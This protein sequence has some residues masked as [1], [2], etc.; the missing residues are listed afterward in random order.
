MKEKIGAVDTV[1]FR[2]VLPDGTL[3]MSPEGLILQTNNDPTRWQRFQMALGNFLDRIRL[4]SLCRRLGLYKCAG[5][6]MMN[7]GLTHIATAVHDY[8][9]F[10]SVGTSS[11]SPSDYTRNDCVTPVLTRVAAT[12]SYETTYVANDTAVFTGVF[13][14]SAVYT[15]VETGLHTLVTAGI[16]GARQTSCSIVTVNGIPFGIIWKVAIVRG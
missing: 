6:A 13:Y 14:P 1:E 9:G 3:D 8:Y 2:K 4:D 15:I 7:A 11:S 10:I 12:K 16:M 5:D